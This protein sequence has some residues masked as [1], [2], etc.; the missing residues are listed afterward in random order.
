[1]E[2]VDG[3]PG[4]AALVRHDPIARGP[5]RQADLAADLQEPLCRVRARRA[6]ERAEVG[7]VLG[8]DDEHVLRRLRIEVVKRDDVRVAED[9]AGRDL[10]ADDLTKEAGWIRAHFLKLIVSK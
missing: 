6:G 8:G 2:V 3:L 5:E 10:T 9:F 4:V 7:R 1:M